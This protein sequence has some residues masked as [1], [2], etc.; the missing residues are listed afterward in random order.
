MSIALTD[1]ALTQSP[2][3]T[4]VVMLLLVVFK[5]G[6]ALLVRKRPMVTDDDIATCGGLNFRHKD[7]NVG[8]CRASQCWKLQTFGD[9]LVWSVLWRFVHVAAD[10]NNADFHLFH[11]VMCAF[12][13]SAILFMYGFLQPAILNK[14]PEVEA[15]C[16]STVRARGTSTYTMRSSQS[17]P[18]TSQTNPRRQPAG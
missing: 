14:L 5:I 11:H 3:L 8:Y 4:A 17:P 12:F 6:V 15:A 7:T 16:E 9:I 2:Q 1:V 13:E 18:Q 10:T